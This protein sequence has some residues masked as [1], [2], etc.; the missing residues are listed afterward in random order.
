MGCHAKKCW[1]PV[2]NITVVWCGL[3][4]H[5]MF[6]CL[7]PSS[8]ASFLILYLASAAHSKIPITETV[9]WSIFCKYFSSSFFAAP[10]SVLELSSREASPKAPLAEQEK[11]WTC[12]SPASGLRPVC[13][14]P[15]C[16]VLESVDRRIKVYHLC[17]SVWEPI[18]CLKY[19]ANTFEA[20]LSL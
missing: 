10:L 17:L 7:T 4:Q 15:F 1:M 3:R 5:P 6:K 2:D 20:S 14:I 11:V 16:W 19:G 9:L 12:W 13:L 18:W 8:S